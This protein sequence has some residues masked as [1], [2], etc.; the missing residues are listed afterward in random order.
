MKAKQLRPATIVLALVLFCLPWLEIRCNLPHQGT[1]VRVETTQSGLQMVYGGTTTTVDGKAPTAA[2]LKK[3]GQEVAGRDGPVPLVGVCLVGLLAAL[4]AHF[5]VRDR[6]LRL[7]WTT[8]CSG[9]GA[10]ALV[11]QVALGFPLVK[12]M[13][14]GEGG[15]TYTPWFWLALAAVIAV[16][17]TSFMD[18][19]EATRGGEELPSGPA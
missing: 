17:M 9:V 13:P 14:R 3:V 1:V 12:D 18:T 2:D 7:G 4:I 11:V 6:S 10:A 19:A 5:A 8:L 15:W 16:P